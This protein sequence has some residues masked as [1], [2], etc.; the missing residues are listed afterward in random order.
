MRGARHRVCARRR[1]RGGGRAA[2]VEPRGDARRA[3]HHSVARVGAAGLARPALLVGP[4]SA[5]GPR[6]C[7]DAPGDVAGGRGGKGGRLVDAAHR[8]RE[9]QLVARA[10]REAAR[11]APVRG[12]PSRSG[13]L[14][15]GWHV[16]AVWRARDVPGLVPKRPPVDGA[17]GALRIALSRV[18]RHDPAW[19]AGSGGMGA[20]DEGHGRDAGLS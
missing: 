18:S 9:S 1:A 5:Q 3:A 14:L 6:G 4:K 12:S 20:G 19:A 2:W 10:V 7:T 15:G 8:A 13:V 11:A 17:S 16:A